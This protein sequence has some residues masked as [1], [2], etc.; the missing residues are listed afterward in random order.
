M[1]YI[2]ISIGL[3]GA[4]R[5]MAIRHMPAT[6]FLLWITLYPLFKSRQC[7]AIGYR[8]IEGPYPYICALELNAR[9][10]RIRHYTSTSHALPFTVYRSLRIVSRK[11]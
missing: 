10:K 4:Q 3:E 5:L 8:L 9:K 7:N 6:G 2:I 11:L 1:K